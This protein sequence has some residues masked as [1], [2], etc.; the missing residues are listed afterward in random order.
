M[1]QNAKR[2]NIKKR[3]HTQRRATKKG[4]PDAIAA[5]CSLQYQGTSKL[6]NQ[7]QFVLICLLSGFMFSPKCHTKDQFMN[8]KQMQ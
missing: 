2:S 1:E 5:S 6:L 4:V 3:G 8:M 7:F